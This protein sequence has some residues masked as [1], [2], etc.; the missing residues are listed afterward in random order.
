MI[1]YKLLLI[2]QNKPSYPSGIRNSNHMIA[3]GLWEEFSKLRHVKLVYQDSDSPLINHGP[4]DFTLMHCYT[5]CPIFKSELPAVRAITSKKMMYISE[6]MLKRANAD[7][8]FCFLE[9]NDWEKHGFAPVEEIRLPYIS[10]FMDNV[11]KIPGSILLDHTWSNGTPEKLWCNKLYEWLGPIKDSVEVGQLLRPRIKSDPIPSWIDGIP[12]MGYVD[13]LA[14]TSRYENYIMTH[15]ESYGHSIIDTN[16]SLP[17]AKKPL[18]DAL[19]LQVF[20]TR[21]ELFS[22]LASPPKTEVQ[23]SAFTDMPEIVRRI[24]EYCQ[25]ELSNGA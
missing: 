12:E 9:F 7:R 14:R 15:A 5:D 18:V 17:F 1:P 11:E 23:K 3:W 20:R 10:S 6:A 22:I 4:I 19:G 24:D 2:S 13:Y 25:K 16:G 21:E 8:N